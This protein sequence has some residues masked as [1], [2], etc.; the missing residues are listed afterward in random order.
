MTCFRPETRDF[1]YRSTSKTEKRISNRLAQA[2]NLGL[3]ER[4]PSGRMRTD[5]PRVPT[6][7]CW[8]ALGDVP[9]ETS[10]PTWTFA[11]A[12]T[13]MMMLQW[14]VTELAREERTPR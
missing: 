14:L 11:D 3:V 13:A 5:G 2:V 8:A 9:A 1:E 12:Q 10:A 7:K 6:A 4:M